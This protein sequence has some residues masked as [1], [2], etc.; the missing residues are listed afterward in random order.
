MSAAQIVG[1]ELGQLKIDEGFSEIPYVDSEGYLTI[2]YGTCIAYVGDI[3]IRPV[4]RISQEHAV[5]LLRQSA[6]DVYMEMDRTW[7]WFEY[8]PLGVKTVMLNMAYNLG[9]PRLAKFK[10]TLAFIKNHQYEK[11]ADEMLRDSTGTGRSL[12]YQ[13]VGHRA[14]RLSDRLR[15]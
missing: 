8:M 15:G 9:V 4:W 6:V 2:G 5:Q 1:A 13:Q 12:W 14:K 7:P 11:A 3:E 10:K